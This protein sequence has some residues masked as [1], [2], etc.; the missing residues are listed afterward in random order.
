MNLS[1][2][3]AW[4]TKRFGADATGSFIRSVPLTTADPAAASMSL[5]F[6]PQTFTDEGAGGTPPDGRDFNGILNFLSAWAQWQGAGGAVPFNSTIASNGGYPKGA[7][8][9]STVSPSLVW[10]N[11]ADGNTTN[12]DSGGTANW[13]ALTDLG[14]LRNSTNGFITIGQYVLNFGSASL[15]GSSGFVD[16]TFAK[17][18][19]TGVLTSGAT[20]LAGS[21]AYPASWPG[22][23]NFSLTGM[24][25]G[26]SVSASPGAAGL[27]A[28][29][30]TA[31]TWWALGV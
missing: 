11:Q 21:P 24:R 7:Q 14:Y 28:P 20:N 9:F 17:P 2:I 23:S 30:G 19:V 4:F 29:A 31:A 6:P 1:D 26:M 27:P 3:P 5:G 8:V 13:A 12:P 22:V 16:V 10:V 15:L 18:F 25:V